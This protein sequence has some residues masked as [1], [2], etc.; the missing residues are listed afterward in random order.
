[1]SN[2]PITLYLFTFLLV[3]LLCIVV[4]S[5]FHY[6]IL[7]SLNVSCTQDPCL[8]LSQFAAASR[9]KNET[10]ISLFLLP[11]NH[12]LDKELF[13]GHADNFSMIN[14]PHNNE[15]LIIV[16]CTNSLARF[17][18]IMTTFVS[19]KGLHFIGCGYNTLARVSQF[20]LED[21]IFQGVEGSGRALELRMVYAADIINSTFTHCSEITTFGYGGTILV[22]QSS[23]NLTNCT[24]ISNSA[25]YAGALVIINS[26]FS[27]I[28]STFADNSADYEDG[29]IY[30]AASSFSIL[31]SIFTNNRAGLHGGV[32]F[33]SECLFNITACNFT[34]NRAVN[35]SGGMATIINSSFNIAHS[36][37]TNNSA[38][39]GGTIVTERCSVGITACTFTSNNH[40]AT[41]YGGVMELFES[42]VS[43]T[44]SMFTENSAVVGGG[45]IFATSSSLEIMSCTF[46][47]NSIIYGGGAV[48]A[49]SS[50]FL[51]SSSV[52]I[53]NC[54]FRNNQGYISA[55]IL[56]SGIS[57]HITDGTFENNVG[58]ISAQSSNI[59]FSGYTKFE[60]CMELPDI[61]DLD[62]VNR[63]QGGVITSFKSNVL[64]LG[65]SH[66][67]YNQARYGG[68]I[69]ATES[70]IIV[71][72]EVI[73]DNNKASDNSG[74]GIHL[75][76]SNLEIKGNCSISNN[77]AV[78]GGGG[79]Y[80]GSSTIDVYKPGLLQ[81]I[82]NSA[83]NGGG[84][85]FGID[86]RL[87]LLKPFDDSEHLLTFTSNHASYGGAVYVADEANSAACL[88]TSL[89]FIQILGFGQLVPADPSTVNIY[90]SK[91]SAKR[92]GSNL[93]GGAT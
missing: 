76:Q 47:N 44:S 72:G 18:I 60:N 66:L 30:V 27:I 75:Q 43:I 90:F 19:I 38:Q 22:T 85:Y 88:P 83:E 63:Q 33:I 79:I 81:F 42:S 41:H 70:T 80:A 78:K 5:E 36:T 2:R 37:F 51:N 53:S 68:A 20:T 10:D 92:L 84:I 89:C 7:P 25:L 17:K 4:D 57:V 3:S 45:V 34:N 32:F 64:F 11:G 15:A 58:S 86:P 59:T 87:N 8:T 26:F 71:Y 46:I 48:M 16:E 24:F 61:I 14:E 6:H 40:N 28:N 13:V 52:V 74:G 91:N 62:T 67:S 82:N 73:I 49:I 9:N 1:M 39:I 35:G 55:I 31:S 21:T 69:L 54:T 65:K 93:F 23:F 77:H 12:S 56:V 50:S 29:S